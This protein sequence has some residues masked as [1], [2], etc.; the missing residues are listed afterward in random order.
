MLI[1]RLRRSSKTL[2]TDTEGIKFKVTYAKSKSTKM[3]EAED[4]FELSSGTPMETIYANHA[5]K[6]KR[7]AETAR[8]QSRETEPIKYSPAAKKTYAPEVESLN[9][10]LAIAQLNSPLERQAQAI[11]NKSLKTL[12]DNDPELRVDKDSYKKANN[13][14]LANARAMVGAK[15]EPI[16]IT[17]KEWEAIQ[18]GAISNNKLTQIFANTDDEQLKK[19]NKKKKKNGLTAAQKSRAKMLLKNG[20]PQSEVAEALG[21]SVNTLRNNV[22]F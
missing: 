11:A 18:A 6:L 21:I 15:K 17:N 12:V 16:Q 14:C 5:N 19:L 13:R 20:Y 8:K 7:L 9:K 3:A 4:A 1:E 10:K 22:E 2:P